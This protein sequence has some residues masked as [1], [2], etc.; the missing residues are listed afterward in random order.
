MTEV[1][2]SSPD[3][4]SEPHTSTTIPYRVDWLLC[5]VAEVLAAGARMP[6]H[7][8]PSTATT[9]RL[10]GIRH[11]GLTLFAD[12]HDGDARIQLVAD[13]ATTLEFENLTRASLGDWIVARGHLTRTR[14]GELSLAVA[15]WQPLAR[16]TVG[17]PDKRAGLRDRDV[18]YRQ[19]HIDLWV[20]PGVRRTF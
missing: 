1:V 9:G 8:E 12:L 17:F 20:T 4:E 16:S 5:S 13:A 15:E 7:E 18:R 19:R 14:R 2:E 3:V 6:L 10:V 11:H